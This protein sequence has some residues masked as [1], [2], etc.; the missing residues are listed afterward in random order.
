MTRVG[1]VGASGY[2]GGELLRIL[3]RH[4][5]VE[6]VRATSRRYS[7]QMVHVVHPN[8]RGILDLKFE[9]PEP[10]RIGRDCDLVFTATPHK[11]SMEIV[12]KLLDGGGKVVDLSG[13][14]RFNDIS[15]YE[16]YYG[17]KHIAPDIKGVY[18]LPEIHR[19]EIKKANLV[20]NPGCYPTTCILG[21]APLLKEG[22]IEVDRIAA[23]SKSGI[24]GAGASPSTS[25]HFCLTNE[26]ILAYK[27][28]SHRHLPEIEQE[29]SNFQKGVKISF[30]P[31]LVPIN[32][33]I[34]T[35]LHCFLS[36]SKSE[37]E[38]K[39]FYDKFFGNEPFIRVL[40]VGEVP[41]LSS[42]RGSNFNDIGCFKIDEERD[43]LIIVSAQDNLVKGASG[44][45]VQNMNLMLGFDETLG[46][47]AIGLSP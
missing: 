26:S 18:G 27:T 25:T 1:V 45:A 32:R 24:T 21:L 13:D 44:Q 47:E 2:S 40:D 37:K 22:V 39:S 19:E 17:I 46:L 16:K 38:I 31:H 28:T 35:T 23:D 43:R 14:F 29:L 10:A 9:D 8:L 6:V 7:N 42:V 20:A 15:T 30:V 34:T 4:P 33:G 3:A 12:P 41:R 11:T 5:K 36:L